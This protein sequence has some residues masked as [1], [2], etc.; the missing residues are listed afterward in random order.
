MNTTDPKAEA[1]SKKCPMHLLPPVGLEQ[2]ARAHGCGA[3]KYGP[4]NWRENGIKASTYEAAIMRHFTAWRNGED[5]DQDSGLSHLAHI[6]AS[7]NIM[8]D[9]IAVGKLHDDR[10]KTVESVDIIGEW[11]RKEQHV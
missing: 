9:A 4:Y 11:H 3:T 8:L 2:V 1:G 10:A 6:G 7:I 5:D